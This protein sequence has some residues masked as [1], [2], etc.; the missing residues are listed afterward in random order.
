[1][2]TSS[3]SDSFESSAKHDEA[4][5]QDKVKSE[6]TWS[7]TKE[8]ASKGAAVGRGDNWHDYGPHVQA[9]KDTLDKYSTKAV[10]EIYDHNQAKVFQDDTDRLRDLEDEDKKG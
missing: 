8:V 1:M 5:D 10:Q 4:Q 3:S 7:V 6:S 2:G 9:I